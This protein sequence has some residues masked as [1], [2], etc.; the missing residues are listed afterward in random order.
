MASDK[1]FNLIEY[2]KLAMILLFVI[3]AIMIYKR[4]N[5]VKENF[6]SI[7]SDDLGQMLQDIDKLDFEQLKEFEKKLK[8]KEDSDEQNSKRMGEILGI[9]EDPADFLPVDLDQSFDD[10]IDDEVDEEIDDEI[11]DEH[12]RVI[13]DLVNDE[14]D[15]EIDFGF[16]NKK[17]KENK[18]EVGQLLKSSDVNKIR[19]L[20]ED[21]TD[22]PIPDSVIGK[23][24]EILA[25]DE[26]YRIMGERKVLD[27]QESGFLNKLLDVRKGIDKIQTSVK[28]VKKVDLK[29]SLGPEVDKELDKRFK[30]NNVGIFDK[31]N[32]SKLIDKSDKM[33]KYDLDAI[34]HGQPSGLDE[35]SADYKELDGDEP[36]SVKPSSD[37]IKFKK[38]SVSV[39][40]RPFKY[41]DEESII[42]EEEIYDET[43]YKSISEIDGSDD[44]NVK[45]IDA[46]VNDYT[47]LERDIVD[48]PDDLESDQDTEIDKI[49]EK[50]ETLKV[51]DKNFK[52]PVN[53]TP[54]D[55]T[56]YEKRIV[57]SP[58]P[59][60][61]KDGSCSYRKNKK[62]SFTI[63]EKGLESRLKTNV[64]SGTFISPNYI[65]DISYT[66][67]KLD[68][69]KYDLENEKLNDLRTGKVDVPIELNKLYSDSISKPYQHKSAT[70]K[71][72][73]I[74][75][76]LDLNKSS[77]SYYTFNPNAPTSREQQQ[78]IQGYNDD[79]SDYSK[80]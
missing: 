77:S 21:E 55:D 37:K 38:P 25:E 72:N 49:L 66:Q 33:F 74:Q 41:K 44:D 22:G 4:I 18:Y 46:D 14:D 35:E 58:E 80:Y 62:K 29:K 70:K 32:L 51:F 78:L 43:R 64:K 71:G 10:L 48:S 5:K 47:E 63:D 59:D 73:L 56:Y 6:E 28:K 57:D 60:C 65:D 17:S 26:A 50:D 67:M 7:D 2:E 1:L 3:F 13:D 61:I 40:K 53:V 69:S 68:K 31:P 75:S 16:I 34:S 79:F 30:Q 52:N 12:D 36:V 15:E 45:F 27:Q 9:N 76:G 39:E 24:Q 42:F 23:T 11:E 19:D 20:I 54:I 8:N